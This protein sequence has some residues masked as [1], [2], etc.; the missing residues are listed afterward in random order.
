M[1]TNDRR[2]KKEETSDLF[3]QTFSVVVT[4]LSVKERTRLIKAVAGTLS[5]VVVPPDHVLVP[6]K[7]VAGKP[8]SVEP[9]RVRQ[10]TTPP[11]P[12]K[13]TKLEEDLLLARKKVQERKAILAV[14]KLPTED[15]TLM[16]HEAALKAYKAEKEKLKLSQPAALPLTAARIKNKRK[17]SERSP[18]RAEAVDDSPQKSGGVFNR[19]KEAVVGKKTKT[20]KQTA[21]ADAME[22]D[23]AIHL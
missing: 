21:K 12:L 13:G 9:G 19:V 2:K 23:D 22:E 10:R 18:E 6:S 8:K 17:A 14:D 16:A 15:P 1:A 5:L 3:D 20:P 11:N 4:Q 7:T